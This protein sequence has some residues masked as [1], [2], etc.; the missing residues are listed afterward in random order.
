[1]KR[2]AAWLARGGDAHA[3]QEFDI[4]GTRQRE[5]IAVSKNHDISQ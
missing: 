2:A 5:S 4:G 3:L 1:M